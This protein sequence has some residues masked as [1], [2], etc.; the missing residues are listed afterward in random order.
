M[1]ELIQIYSAD[2]VDTDK[3][4][5]FFMWLNK[6]YIRFMSYVCKNLLEN[7]NIWVYMDEDFVGKRWIDFGSSD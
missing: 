1:Y 3:R 7:A 6:V 5:G 2:S 4:L